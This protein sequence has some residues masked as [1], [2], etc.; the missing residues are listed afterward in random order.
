MGQ[1]L[2]ALTGEPEVEAGT[3]FAHTYGHLLCLKVLI[4]KLLALKG[5]GPISAMQQ[6]CNLWMPVNGFMSSRKVEGEL[7]FLLASRSGGA[8]EK[9]RVKKGAVARPC[10]EGLQRLCS[11]MQPTRWRWEEGLGGWGG[12]WMKVPPGSVQIGEEW[13]CQPYKFKALRVQTKTRSKNSMNIYA[14][15]FL[16]I[17]RENQKEASEVNKEERMIFSEKRQR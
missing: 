8:K 12:K 13:I 1:D 9:T 14:E 3:N 5:T 10:E 7:V 2:H 6:R 4:A 16:A 15:V 11:H 17:L